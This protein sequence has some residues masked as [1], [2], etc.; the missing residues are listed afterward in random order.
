MDKEGTKLVH[1]NIRNNDF[2]YFLKLAEPYKHDL[3]VACE[4]IFNWYWLAD[5]CAEPVILIITDSYD[6]IERL[7]RLPFYIAVFIRYLSQA[8]KRN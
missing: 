7:L 6:L 3:T 1:K 4:C 8:E 5:A 2:E